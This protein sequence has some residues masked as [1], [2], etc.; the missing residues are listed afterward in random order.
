M[1]TMNI[2]IKMIV[3]NINSKSLH[4]LNSKSLKTRSWCYNNVISY[5]FLARC[6]PESI[7]FS[8]V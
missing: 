2:M 6:L 1:T 3:V 8:L 7:T 5:T 4:N